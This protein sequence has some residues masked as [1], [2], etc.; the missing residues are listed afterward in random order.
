M[1]M[2]PAL[3]GALALA[4]AAL[5]AGLFG[6]LAFGRH[7]R[8]QRSARTLDHALKERMP[9][10]AATGTSRDAAPSQRGFLGA[11]G[12]AGA[13]W[14]DTPFG[15][16]AVAD[17]DR[18]LL[19]RCGYVDAQARGRFFA[20]RVAGALIAPL[21]VIAAGHGAAHGARF[22]MLLFMALSMGFMAPKWFVKRRA[23]ARQRAVSNE[24]PL[25]VD[26]LRLL[27]GVGLSLD[28][29]LQVMIGDFRNVLPV[30]AKELAL[31][32]AQF[33]TGRTREQSMKRLATSYENEDLAAI[34]R[35][36]IQVEQHGGAVQEPLR[37]FGDR[38]RETRRALLRERIG[39]LTV[40][41]TGVMVITLLPALL[42]ITAGPGFI[43]VVHALSGLHR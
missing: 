40:K 34:V 1:T 32:Q 28:Q 16:V 17:E 12:R 6:V 3:L 7:A 36:V 37:Q 18:R 25:F 19:E 26:L 33:A 30:L 21:V 31:A 15:R 41:M 24:L 35:L 43:A 13:A 39:K 20:A 4:A 29:S 9:A 27:Q 22:M 14:L 11:L 5:A 38:L 2:T 8:M 42:I 10:P 23:Q